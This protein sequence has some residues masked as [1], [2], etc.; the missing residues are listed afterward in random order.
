MVDEKLYRIWR[1][2]LAGSAY[3]FRH[4]WV[5]VHQILVTHDL[6]VRALPL[7]RDYMYASP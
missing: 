5:A 3:A 1:V 7:T 2:Y 4:N 6:G